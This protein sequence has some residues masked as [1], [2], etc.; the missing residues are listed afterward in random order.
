M[1]HGWACQKSR[2]WTVHLRHFTLKRCSKQKVYVDEQSI[3]LE[4]NVTLDVVNPRM[5]RRL[6]IP[7]VS[8]CY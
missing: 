5:L 8:K 7:C 2:G 1:S 4:N 6:D 3:H